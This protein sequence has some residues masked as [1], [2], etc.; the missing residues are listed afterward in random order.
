MADTFNARAKP[1]SC[2]TSVLRDDIAFA[3][4]GATD[5]DIHATAAAAHVTEFV[6]QLPD[7]FATLVGERGVEC[8]GGRR[9]RVVLAR[10]IVCGAPILLLDEVWRLMDGRAA[11]VAA[12]RPSAA[13]KAG[14]TA[15]RQ[16]RSRLDE[17]STHWQPA[18]A[19]LSIGSDEAIRQ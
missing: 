18:Q 10:A 13:C 17:A 1:G 9:Q 15:A 11:L 2:S 8:L 5:E 12:H 14:H 7:G 19:R 4:P 16:C 3:R 6:D